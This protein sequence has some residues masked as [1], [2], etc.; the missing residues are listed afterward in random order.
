MHL[1]RARWLFKPFP[2]SPMQAALASLQGPF[3]LQPLFQ[4]GVEK[5][6]EK[7]DSKNLVRERWLTRKKVGLYYKS[8]FFSGWRKVVLQT[9]IFFLVREKW[10][11][12]KKNPSLKNHFSRTTFLHS[13]RKGIA[14]YMAVSLEFRSYHLFKVFRLHELNLEHLIIS[15]FSFVYFAAKQTKQ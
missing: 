5:W 4:K 13:S 6:F 7:S 3:N 2:T 1:F 11:T 8:T 10:L 15:R 12:R 14:D 9:R